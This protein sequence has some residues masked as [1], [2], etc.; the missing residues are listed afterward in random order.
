MRNFRVVIYK[1]IRLYLKGRVVFLV[2][3]ECLIFNFCILIFK[4]IVLKE[5]IK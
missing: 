5:R 4:E 3:I 2:G 1:S